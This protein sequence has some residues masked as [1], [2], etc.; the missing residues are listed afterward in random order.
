MKPLLPA[1]GFALLAG[2]AP[3][4][5]R[6]Q[7]S[8]YVNDAATTGDIYTAAPGDDELGNGSAAAP[9]ATVDRA[10][11]VAAPGATIFIDA[12]SYQQRMVLYKPVNLQGAGD[13]LSSP[14]SATIFRDGPRTPDSEYGGV[15]A[16]R[17]NVGGSAAQ[18]IRISRMSLRRYDYAITGGTPGTVLSHVTFEDVDVSKCF[19]QGIE[20]AG[21]VSDLTFRRVGVRLTRIQ[22]A[23]PGGGAPAISGNNYGRGLF[24]NGTDFG[25]DKRNLLIENC[26]FEQNRRAG[27]DVNER[28]TSN[29]V[30][31]GCRFYGNLGPAL[32]VLK[33][34]GQRDAGGNYTSIGAL[35]EDN[36]IQDNADNGLEIKSSTGTGLSS[37]P[38]SFVV[39]RNR[40]TRNL[41]LPTEL[42]ADNA[43]IAV[44]DRDRV[45]AGRPSFNDDLSTAGLWIEANVIRG[46]RSTASVFFSRNGF[47]IVLE[48]SSHQVRH[49]VI[50]RCQLGVQVQDRPATTAEQFTPFFDIPRN[51]LL[52]SSGVMVQ[53]NLLDSCDVASVRA[54]NLTNPANISLNWLGSNV[55]SDIRGASGTG[56]LVRTLLASNFTYPEVSSL[57]PTGRLQFSPFLNSRTDVSAEAGF[58]PDLS[59]LRVAANVPDAL[60]AGNMQEAALAIQ[61]GGTIEAEGGIYNE[62][63]TVT[64]NV[65]LRQTNP[66]LTL[67]DLTLNGAGKTLTL[68]T[69]LTLSGTLTLTAGLISSTATDLL[70]LAAGSS[71]TE[72][73]AGSYVDGP[74]SKVGSTAFV[75]PLGRGGVW[76]RLGISAPTA[77]STFTA[78]YVAQG[79]PTQAAEPG[80]TNISRVEYW[81]LTRPAGNGDVSVQLYWEDGGRSGI[82]SLPE[83]RVARFDGTVWQNEGNGGA[84]GS[85]S[86]G[87]IASAGPVG[88]FG[89]FTFGSTSPINPLPVEL[90]SFRGEAIGEG[91]ARLTWTTAQ[92]KNNRGFEVER[93]LNGKTWEKVG[94]V[95]GQGT[96]TMA[97]QYSFVDAVGLSSVVYYRLR[98]LDFDGKTQLSAVVAVQLAASPGELSLYPNPAHHELTILLPK[99]EAAQATVQVLDQLGRVV[100]TTAAPVSGQRLNLQL[101]DHLKPGI[102]VVRVSG[103]GLPT[104]TKR[105][106]VE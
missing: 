85:A 66:S 27:I 30:V 28:A 63:V 93:A 2:L 54:V 14:A 55:I 101:A 49:N 32:S 100:W 91:R 37:G 62:A 52:V 57:A 22:S 7:T 61:D 67:R 46:Y 43:A 16:L 98:Q 25:A 31:R 38:G 41:S 13:S 1:L 82:N 86:A 36:V 106:V 8:V 29:L 95:A 64:K 10:M 99:T 47:G 17:L 50:T 56:G 94:F 59:Y 92:E 21:D 26:A 104:G 83:L 74:M 15:A 77:G 78:E 4:G 105:L 60:P 89:P 87:A 35:I 71:S 18:P 81:N 11:A 58:Q 42:V 88:G 73:N 19:R 23:T 90:T 48:G 6:A 3:A 9:F 45:V 79:Y 102:Y 34:A 12:G 24:F 76:A 68:A 69:P 65:T 103:K 40:I 44:V 70:T 72:G 96:S 80:L 39:R 75:F 20:L 51:Q 97:H 5:V 53:E 84:T 33:V